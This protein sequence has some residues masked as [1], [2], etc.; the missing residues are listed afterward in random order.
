M[1]T[2]CSLLASTGGDQRGAYHTLV[3][4]DG[5]FATG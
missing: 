4:L 5:A 3:E 1:S 2:A